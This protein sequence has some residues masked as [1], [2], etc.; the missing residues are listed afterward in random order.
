[1]SPGNG[2]DEWK[3]FV[4]GELKDNKEDH[5]VMFAKLDFLIQSMNTL[6]TEVKIKSG[7]WGML[8]GAIPVTIGLAI[9]ILKEL[10]SG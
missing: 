4:L 8:A 10:I 7:V 9:W 3:H 2:W 5:K 1:M 6:K